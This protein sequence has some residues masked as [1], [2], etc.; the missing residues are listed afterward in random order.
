MDEGVRDHLPRG[1]FGETWYSCSRQATAL[2]T[3]TLDG[4]HIFGVSSFLS[5]LSVILINLGNSFSVYSC[6]SLLLI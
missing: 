5:H 2:V 3:M 4:T 1:L 6:S